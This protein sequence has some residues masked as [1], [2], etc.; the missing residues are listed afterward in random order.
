MTRWEYLTVKMHEFG[1]DEAELKGHNEY[2]VSEYGLLK[3]MHKLGG[4][5]WETVCTFGRDL[6]FKRPI[7]EGAKSAVVEVDDREKAGK[8]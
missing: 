1:S 8:K 6:I 3:V 4:E 2:W 5:G 7:M